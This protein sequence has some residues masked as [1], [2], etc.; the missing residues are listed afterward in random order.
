MP[1][2]K[3]GILGAGTMWKQIALLCASHKVPVTV[4]N[5]VRR[6]DFERDL[7]KIAV[8]QSRLSTID[9]EDIDTILGNIACVEDMAELEPCDLLIE[10]VKEPRRKINLSPFTLTPCGFG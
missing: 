6:A 7:R 3:I 8:L 1:L 5:H 10:A 4:W 9:K 2:A